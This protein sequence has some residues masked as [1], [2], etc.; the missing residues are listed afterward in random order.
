MFPM[1]NSREHPFEEALDWLQSTYTADWAG[2]YVAPAS[3][4]LAHS[5][6]AEG[7]KLFPALL[8]HLVRLYP[9]VYGPTVPTGTAPEQREFQIG[10]G[11]GLSDGTRV[12]SIKLGAYAGRFNHLNLA[13]MHNPSPN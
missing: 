12:N 3:T 4:V 8:A 13:G 11:E 9:E 2:A 6:V 1:L 7:D 10:E 5:A